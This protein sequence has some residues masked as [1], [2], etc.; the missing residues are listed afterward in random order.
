M[1]ITGIT[2]KIDELGRIVLPKEIRKTLNINTGDDF[3][4]SIENEKIILQRYLKLKNK[5]KEILKIIDP[6]IKIYNYKIY[7]IIGNKFAMGNMF[8]YINAGIFLIL[9]LVINSI[10]SKKTNTI[11]SIFSILIWSIIIDVICYYM[12]PMMS[13]GQNLLTYVGQGI[14]FNYK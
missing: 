9:S 6:F 14:L 5:E 7:M 4:I 11:L 3:Q 1:I 13:M 12:Y 10:K 2:R 8:V